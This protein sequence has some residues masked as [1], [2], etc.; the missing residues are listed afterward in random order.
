MRTRIKTQRIVVFCLAILLATPSLIGQFRSKSTTRALVIGIS[1]YQDELIPDLNYAHSD[2]SRF[3]TY[4][5]T[6]S[7][8]KVAPENITL[9]VNEEATC[10]NVH[11]AL[12]KLL[13]VSKKNDKVFIFFSGHGDVETI[14]DT[15]Q[16]HLLLFNSSA[17]VYQLCSIK[18]EHLKKVITKLSNENEA[19]VILISDAC[20]SG[21]L[22]GNSVNGSQATA[23]AMYQSFTNEI[24]IMSC[25]PN[26]Y[27]HEGEQWNG[28]AFTHFLVKGLAG[29]A[30]NNADDLVNLG[31]IGNFLEFEV[32][33]AVLPKSQTPVV[34]GDKKARIS[35][36]DQ[37]QVKLFETDSNGSDTDGFIGKKSA[38]FF[39]DKFNRAIEEKR[40]IPGD[41]EEKSALEIYNELKDQQSMKPI[42]RGLK[43][44]LVSALQD[45][46]Q[47]SIKAYLKADNRELKERF[48][49]K[50]SKYSLFPEYMGAAADL[51]GQEHYLYQQMIAKKLYFLA[52]NTRLKG[53]NEKENKIEYYN[54]ALE[55]IQEA[56][57]Y[58]ERA[59]YIYNELGLISYRL[60]DD[61][62]EEL[63]RRAIALSPTW[64]MP[65]SNLG[66]FLTER[67]RFDEAKEVSEKAISLKAN[68]AQPYYNLSDVAKAE[69][70]LDKAI[71]YSKEALPYNEKAGSLNYIGILHVQNSEYDSAVHYYHLALQK[72]SMLAVTYDN[73]GNGYNKLGKLNLAIKYFEKA[74]LKNPGYWRY[75]Y[76][77]GIAH[78]KSKDYI[79]SRN[80]FMRSLEINPDHELARM[81]Y[82]I[83]YY[84]LEN[85]QEAAEQ[86]DY[87][88][89]KINK[90]NFWPYINSASCY[91]KIN[92]YDK[93]LERLRQLISIDFSDIKLLT[94]SSD[95][96]PLHDKA[97]FLKIIEEIKKK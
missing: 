69:G 50:G 12:D 64:A 53:D 62:C 60:G 33:Q 24:K 61:N 72:D 63:Y 65:Y 75:W 47:E 95:L 55:Y 29:L 82:G 35:F 78:Q 14:D 21:A 92:E 25:Q 11:Q 1:D 94:D 49:R 10:G 9:L 93:A 16:G 37:G 80:A 30:D 86:F 90:D 59:A 38:G 56:L 40:F 91:A 89:A 96:K 34:Q 81:K 23:S 84:Y 20:R 15:E 74:T 67:D 2:A 39:K 6:S 17:S 18:I 97:E 58:E 52:V 3:S 32:S 28:G 13:E 27:S 45:D 51:L 26:E 70:N 57:F 79:A 66:Y 19:K 76:N 48:N 41:G 85:Y 36:V 54:K 71:E 46:V 7:G 22:A 8:G 5:Q 43:G 42:L 83:V 88:S 87:I 31:E 77:L 44:D 68:I 4:L 73:L